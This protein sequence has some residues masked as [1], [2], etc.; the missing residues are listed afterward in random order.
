MNA[1]DYVK[2]FNGFLWNDFL[3][4]VLLAVGI[5]YTIYLGFPQIRHFGLMFK[6]AF[7]PAFKR[8]KK[9]DKHAKQDEAHKVNSF[10]ALATAVAAQV[11]TGNIGGVATAIATGGVG[12]IFWMWVSSLLGMGTIFSEATLAQKYREV[13]DGGVAG[14]PAYYISKG[15]KCHPLAVFFALAIILAL[16]CVG[17]MVQANSI[18]IAIVNS[19]GTGSDTM[20]YLPYLIGV[21]LAL[22]VGV[23]IMGGQKRITAIAELVVPFMAL[24]YIL[25]SLV[26][27]FLYIGD[28]P[29]MFQSV[30]SEAFSTKAAAGGAA[31]TVMKY[32]IRYGVARG[33]FSN[34]AGMGSTPHAH[35]MAHVK[36]PAIPGFV[37]MAGVFV[38]TILICSSTAFVI[39]LTG[40]YQGTDLKSVAITQEA[41]SRAFGSGGVAFLAIALFFFAFTTIMGWYMFG[42][43]NVRYLFGKYGVLPFRLIVCGC[44]F[45]GCIFAADLVWELADTF[46]GLMAIPNLIA[47]VWLAPQVRKMYTHFLQRR[48]SGEL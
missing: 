3:M 23:V 38:D 35:A 17:N 5:F 13:K 8:R 33:L 43:M 4:Y 47:I 45:C 28:V 31:G 29:H 10:Q 27:L 18:S 41:F 2:Q 42:E 24:I 22:R 30:V 21:A 14:G 34:E 20:A 25:G 39:M 36:A 6:Y 11:G 37:A 7:G 16:G 9:R 40:A 12:A 19:L 32:A 48:R 15:L 46:N 26:V 44:I 1:L